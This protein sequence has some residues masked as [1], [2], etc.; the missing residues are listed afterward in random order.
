MARKKL[1][2]TQDATSC[3]FAR[4]PAT[5]WTFDPAKRLDT[6]ARI[7]R[8]RIVHLAESSLR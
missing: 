4:T 3:D 5:A 2:K 7:A 1:G 8:L 6:A